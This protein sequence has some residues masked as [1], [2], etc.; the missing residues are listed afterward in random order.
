MGL[1]G[2][3]WNPDLTTRLQHIHKRVARQ[4][5]ERSAAEPVRPKFKRRRVGQTAQAIVA[6]LAGQEEGLRAHA[7]ALRV[8]AQLGESVPPST[9]KSCL[10]REAKSSSGVFERVGRGRYRLRLGP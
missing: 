10:S 8:N 5:G 9:I 7:I 2:S 1:V 6:V 4:A 3:L